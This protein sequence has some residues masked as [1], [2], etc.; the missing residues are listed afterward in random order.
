MS[1]TTNGLGPYAEA[2]RT[3]AQIGAQASDW[4][5]RHPV[6]LCPTVPVSAPLAF[7]DRPAGSVPLWSAKVYG[8]EP[9]LPESV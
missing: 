7:N 2:G 1:V 5:E 9:P 6:A 8:V 4:F 3:L